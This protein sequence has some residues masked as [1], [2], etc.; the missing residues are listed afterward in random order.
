AYAD[1]YGIDIQK[2]ITM[3][4]LGYTDI[5][6]PRIIDLSNET[7]YIRKNLERYLT[8]CDNN[9]G[10]DYAT[11]IQDVNC[12]L[13]RPY[14]TGIEDS[15][16]SKGLLLICNKYYKLPN[17]F[18]L[19]LVRIDDSYSYYS[20]MYL[21]AEAYE[22]FKQLHQAIVNDGLDLY[23][24]SSY[25]SY[26]TQNAI[27]NHYINNYGFDYAEQFSARPGH[28]EHQTGLAIDF[29]DSTASLGAFEDTPQDHWMRENA[30]K[31]GWIL[32]YPKDAV[33]ITGYLYEPWHYRYVGVE[34][35]TKIKELG[36]T[37]EE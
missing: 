26:D 15:D 20:D 6:D 7:Y 32:R 12:N 9:P 13:D 27:Y 3:I 2:A 24:L 37:F 18:S 17:D 23:I 30:H 28:S 19:D 35:A 29:V 4:N 25:R 22:A 5:Y 8:H 16:L 14:Y 34:T 21:N 36:I 10:K 31:Y 1:K 33:H 11:I